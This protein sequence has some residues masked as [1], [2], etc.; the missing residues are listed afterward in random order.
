[1]E[2]MRKGNRL[3]P[4]FVANVKEPGRYCD[5]HGLWFQVGPS[6]TKSWLFV[7]MLH[8]R[9]RQMGLG[10]LHT[11]GLAEARKRAGECRTLLLDGIDPIEARNDQRTVARLKAAKSVNFRTCAERLIASHEGG[12]KS[13]KHKR[14]WRTTLETYAY[15]ILGDLPV[16]AIDT[17]LVMQVLTPIWSTKTETASRVRMRI[18]RV[19]DA[20]KAHGLRSGDNPARWRGHLDNLLAAPRSIAPVKHHPAVPW[21]AVP[22]F[23]SDLRERD[24]MAARALEF[25]A[26]TAL[27]VDAVLGARWDEIDLANKVW[28]VPP[29]RNKGRKATPREHRVPLAPRAIAILQSLPREG[30]HVFPGRSEHGTIADDTLR[31]VLQELRP[32]CTTHGLRSTFKDWAS[33]HTEYPDVVSEMALAHVV[34]D[35]TERAYRRG[36]LFQKRVALM[37]A[38]ASYCEQAPAAGDVVLLH[39]E[40]GKAA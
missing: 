6:G 21:Q 18:E 40:V 1:V 31:T 14:Q 28:T 3:S 38:W 35:A 10:A 20:A 16:A 36:D 8:G 22:Q 4:K 30:E 26:L 27:R 11:V 23:M 17:D 39:G 19:L 12:W 7:Y 15:P 2:I 9:A 34:A 32:G 33:E 24:G 25:T 5:G 37:A 29:E 13:D